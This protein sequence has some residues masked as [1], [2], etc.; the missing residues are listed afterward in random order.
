MSSGFPS[1]DKPVSP[2]A[3]PSFAPKLKRAQKPSEHPRTPEQETES[4]WRW[5]RIVLGVVGAVVALLGLYH[6]FAGTSAL[7]G[8][9]APPDST[10]ES[11]YRF[12]SAYV[13]GSGAS[14]IAISIKFGWANM[15]YVVTGTIFFSGLCRVYSWAV[16]GTPHVLLIVSMI[17]ELAAPPVLVVWY[18]WVRRAQELRSK[19]SH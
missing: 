17:V 15:L 4:D 1:G 11:G 3:K 14:L 6:V 18:L 12:A 19:Y 16:A 10:L 5:F 2:V 8:Y 7:P 13:V 9:N